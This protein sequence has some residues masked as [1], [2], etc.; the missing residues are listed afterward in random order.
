M[1]T[2]V[3]KLFDKA[4]KCLKTKQDYFDEGDLID[5][6]LISKHYAKYPASSDIVAMH[7]ASAH[8]EQ[9]HGGYSDE[10]L[11]RRV[12]GSEGFLI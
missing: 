12:N 2:D 1:E 8:A 6:V 5:W 10:I 11:Y 3:N 7:F 9:T 4:G